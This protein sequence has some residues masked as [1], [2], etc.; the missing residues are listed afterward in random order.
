M[1]RVLLHNHSTWSDG[2]MSLKGVARLAEWLGADAVVMSEHDYCFTSLKW[3][4][5]VGA[6]MNASTSECVIIPGIEYS[7]PDDDFHILTVGTPR[8][9]GARRELVDSL[10][11]IRAEGGATVLAHPLRRNCFARITKEI[12]DQL[13]AIEIWNRKTDGLLPKKAFFQFARTHEL[14]VTVGMD[15]HTWRQSFPMWNEMGPDLKVLD[16]R[17]IAASLRARETVPA[18][19]LGKLV[20]CLSAESSPALTMLS[21][22]EK[23]RSVVRD[24]RDLVRSGWVRSPSSSGH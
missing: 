2:R 9:H 13:D 7:S 22:A 17:S 6:C 23:C 21:A 11:E 24:T 14:G 15:L 20:P 18:C 3:D 5:Y 4:E 12:L 8:F 10:A 16:G 1:N 19:V